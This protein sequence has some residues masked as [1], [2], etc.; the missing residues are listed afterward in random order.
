MELRPI[1]YVSKETAKNMERRAYLKGYRAGRRY[2]EK[3]AD[4]IL[5]AMR[6]KKFKI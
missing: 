2:Y 6:D 5:N 3:Q 1:Y 4:E